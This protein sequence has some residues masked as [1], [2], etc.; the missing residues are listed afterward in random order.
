[1]LKEEEKTN[2]YLSDMIIVNSN[3]ITD[4]ITILIHMK[5]RRDKTKDEKVFS[6]SVIFNKIKVKERI[7]CSEEHVIYC[8]QWYSEQNSG[9]SKV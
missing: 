3:S 2:F 9:E 8:W 7:W 5:A 1:M 4:K 6:L